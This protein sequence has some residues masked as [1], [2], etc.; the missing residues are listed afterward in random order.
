VA[1]DLNVVYPID[2][3]NE[4]ADQGVIGAVAPRHLAFQGAQIDNLEMLRLDTGPAAA[5]LLKDDGV[6]A[7]LLTPICPMCT[8]TLSAVAHTLE[9]HGLPTVELALVRSH[10]E[11]MRP[12]RALFVNFPLG[13][14]L[15][16]PLDPEFQHRVL[17]SAFTLFDRESGPVLEDFAEVIEDRSD[18]PLA[19]PIPVNHDPN[20]LDAVAEARG[21]RQAYERQRAASGRTLVG[22]VITADQ[23]GE[24]LRG[25]QT[26]VDGVPV[27]E[28]N[29]PDDLVALSLDIRSYYE[30][31]ALSLSD[32][33][34]EARAAETWFVQNTAAGRLMQ[35]VRI[36]L[37]DGGQVPIPVWYGFLPG[38]Q[39]PLEM[40][41][42][43]AIM[44]ERAAAEEA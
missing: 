10:A 43:A 20:E 1:A 25:L 33:V 35:S 18:E 41:D 17:A 23:V 27:A 38:S 3:L 7:V 14:P 29:L 26:I 16:R 36:A 4:L 8:R 19:C 30:E 21:L 34:P 42:L 12:P 6:D 11:R 15:G 9:S 22:R 2:R 37:R 44:K 28:A 5:K 40:P 13:R 39:Q 32:H 24:A 31:V